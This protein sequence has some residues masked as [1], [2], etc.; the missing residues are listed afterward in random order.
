MKLIGDTMTN[1]YLRHLHKGSLNLQ[2]M[3]DEAAEQFAINPK[4]D[5]SPAL[6]YG[7]PTLLVFL[8]GGYIYIRRPSPKKQRRV[9]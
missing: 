9:I 2:D 6:K 1:R 7:I 8:I 5:E 3:Q 4:T